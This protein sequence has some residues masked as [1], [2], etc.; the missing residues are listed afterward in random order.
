VPA[1]AKPHR[2]AFLVP[3]LRL[4]GLELAHV[5]EAALL[6]WMACI[7]TC[8]RHANLAVYD[9]ESTPITPRNMH[10]APRHATVGATPTD[11]VFGPTR[12]DEVV[13]L[14]LALSAHKPSVVRLHV[15]GRDGRR[16][17]FDA[18]GKKLGE[19]IDQVLAAWLAARELPPLP[20]RFEAITVDDVIA[21]MRVIGPP[22]VEGARVPPASM[23]STFAIIASDD[24]EDDEGEDEGDEDDDDADD[25]D[26]EEEDDDDADGGFDE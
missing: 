18:I 12:R 2:I 21:T 3:E 22:L 25:D 8:Q 16:Q 13:W 26:D 5:P 15:I 7:E 4:E 23:M 10:F 17:S 1:L 9:A 20:R 11:A 6:L 24:T 19:Q 14:E